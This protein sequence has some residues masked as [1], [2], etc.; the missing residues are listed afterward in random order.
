MR[1]RSSLHTGGR[2]AWDGMREAPA[3]A[4]EEEA[5]TGVPT[6]RRPG[7]KLLAGQLPAARSGLLHNRT[8]AGGRA[9]SP[10]HLSTIALVSK[11]V[12]AQ[13]D[14][15]AGE[16]RR[17]QAAVGCVAVGCITARAGDRAEA[18]SVGLAAPAPGSARAHRRK[19]TC[20]CRCA[21]RRGSVSRCGT[22]LPC[23]CS[24]PAVKGRSRDQGRRARVGWGG[25]R[26]AGGAGG[27]DGGSQS[28]CKRRTQ[29][30]LSGT[31]PARPPP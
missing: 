31:H 7:S 18:D 6:L 30:W 21:R 24:P 14:L 23:W 28:C 29:L 26:A 11:R 22:P 10:R 13:V 9:G 16:C 8:R 20:F 17:V 27:G 3:A 15:G 4:A 2:A 19:R 5:G 1:S 25:Q 12:L